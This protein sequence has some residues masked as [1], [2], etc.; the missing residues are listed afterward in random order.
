MEDIEF[1][2]IR[3]KEEDAERGSLISSG[4]MRGQGQREA[5]WF[6]SSGNPFFFFF[7]LEFVF[8]LRDV[9]FS[10]VKKKK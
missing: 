10:G 2:G 1:G 3:R 6:F 4:I 7:P 5:L 9:K 8:E